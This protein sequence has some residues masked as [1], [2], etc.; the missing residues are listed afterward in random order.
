[1]PVASGKT[2]ADPQVVADTGRVALER[3]PLVYAFEG[4]D[5]AGLVECPR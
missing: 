3:G 1:M 5:L 4:A 2:H